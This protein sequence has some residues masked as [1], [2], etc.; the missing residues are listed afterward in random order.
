[1]I[2][3][4]WLKM[5]NRRYGSVNLILIFL[6]LMVFTCR[7]VIGA[8]SSRTGTGTALRSCAV[9]TKALP[10]VAPSVAPVPEKGMYAGGGG[11]T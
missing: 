3:V 1:M 7:V 5:A 4:S 8:L 2:T 9:N 10:P 6:P 11:A